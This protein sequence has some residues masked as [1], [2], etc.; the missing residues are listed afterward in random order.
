[1][2]V[3]GIFRHFSRCHEFYNRSTILV[4]QVF[5]IRAARG[6]PDKFMRKEALFGAK[7]PS[8]FRTQ[9]L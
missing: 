8:P 7:Q 2:S 1:M 6:E 4:P 9:C 3:M 5:Q